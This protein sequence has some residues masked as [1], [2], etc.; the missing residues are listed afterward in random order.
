MTEVNE[1]ALALLL[2]PKGKCPTIGPEAGSF[3]K[4]GVS[5]WRSPHGSIRYVRAV[6]GRIVAALQVMVR[7]QSAV[8][9]NVYTLP[10]ARRKGFATELWE[11]A[12]ADFP[13]LVA[14]DERS[15]DG[16]NWAR[17]VVKATRTGAIRSIDE[18]LLHKLVDQL[19]FHWGVDRNGLIRDYGGPA[20]TKA[21]FDTPDGKIVETTVYV[22]PREDVKDHRGVFGEHRR[23]S[24]HIYVDPVRGKDYEELKKRIRSV[25]A[26]EVA[27]AVD[28]SSPVRDDEYLNQKHEVTARLVQLVRELR[29]T[30]MAAYVIDNPDVQADEVAELLPTW[31]EIADHLTTENRKRVLKAITQ[32]LE[33]LRSRGLEPITAARE[34][35]DL[36]IKWRRR[37]MKT[38]KLGEK[39]DVQCPNCDADMHEGHG[40]EI[41]CPECDHK[42]VRA[43][44]LAQWFRNSKVVNP[45]GSPKIVYHGTNASFDVFDV[46]RGSGFFGTGIYVTENKA[47]AENYGENL[48]E[49]YARAENPIDL[50]G[51]NDDFD[52]ALEAAGIEAPYKTLKV[53]EFAERAKK[54][55]WDIMAK[56][57]DSARVT[58]S[59]GAEGWVLFSPE[60]VKLV[61]NQSPTEGPS[62]SAMASPYDKGWTDFPTGNVETPTPLKDSPTLWAKIAERTGHEM[63]KGVQQR[64]PVL[65]GRRRIQKTRPITSWFLSNG[66]I[67]TI[68]QDELEA[69]IWNNLKSKRH[70][71]LPKIFDVF[72]IKSNDGV[73]RWGIVHEMITWPP[74]KDW[75]LFVDTFFRWRAMEKDRALHP[76]SPDDLERFLR[77]IIDS[78]KSDPLTVKKKEVESV[79]P[80]KMT[81]ERRNDVTDRRKELIRVKGLEDMIRW[82]K[83]ALKFFH[84]Q[85]VKFRDLDPSNLAVTPQGRV[86]ITNVAESGSSPARTKKTGLVKSG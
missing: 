27:H 50:R 30:K 58:T 68:T 46:E 14:G 73:A 24:I 79:L 6:K 40:K 1:Q 60:Q 62:I 45:D 75:E 3:N 71:S 83:D 10:E 22:V 78:E 12:I 20:Y 52:K 55:R 2:S 16:E 33:A 74:P 49:L 72:S 25:L 19:T 28:P 48:L 23:E 54:L 31:R 13:H 11:A 5:T 38:E 63:S 57:Y 82:A 9:Q 66:K 47:E 56:G 81:R 80:W 43:S 51:S 29:D 53:S 42:E 34:T 15:S 67:L 17:S 41:V 61:S 69:K 44:T 84:S 59:N 18:D 65:G 4:D 32:T 36:R 85:K 37:A 70:T 7:E 21:S 76:A 8:A 77:F 35:D 26:H 64:A 86:V 39:A